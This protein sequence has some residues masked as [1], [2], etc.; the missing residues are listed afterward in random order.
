MHCH[1]VNQ[2]YTSLNGA[3]LMHYAL[4][5][6]K[7]HPECILLCLLIFTMK[8]ANIPFVASP[9]GPSVAGYNQI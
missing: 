7:G 4:F 2:L 6:T 5:S 8:H 1:D 9:K 3:V